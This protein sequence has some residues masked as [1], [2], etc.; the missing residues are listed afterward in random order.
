M[1]PHDARLT[2]ARED[3]A[4]AGLE[5]LAPAA[6]YEQVT[7]MRV[8][9]PRAPVR[10]SPAPSAEQVDQLL[11]GEVF[12]QLELMDGHA[13]GRARRDG[14]VGFVATEALSRDLLAPTHWVAAIR[15]FAFEGPSIKSPSRGPLSLNALV[16]IEEETQALALASGIGW[17]AKTHLRPIGSFFED[18]ADMAWRF[19]G[20]PYL[21]G[22]RDS[23]G[24]DCSGL[25]Q[26]AL[27]ACGFA[28]PRDSDQQAALGRPAPPLALR[29]GDLVFWR[30]HVG[31]MLDGRRLLHANAHRMAVTTEPLVQ[32]EAR[33]EAAG[34]GPPIAFRRI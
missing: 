3:L 2:L 32:A 19:L 26:Q 6:R 14:Y 21:W 23:L 33:I 16:T 17:I 10:V 20:S 5:G 12:D 31:M 11:F 13:W 25:V 29:R 8:I 34:G 15:T 9:Q 4:C 30:G 1:I 28:C 27:Y 7:S 22:G 18:P 24:L